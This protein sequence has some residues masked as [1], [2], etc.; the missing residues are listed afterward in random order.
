MYYL[1]QVHHPKTPDTNPEIWEEI[2]RFCGIV[3]ERSRELNFDALIKDPDL[4]HKAVDRRWV[5]TYFGGGF[6]V[7]YVSAIDFGV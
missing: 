6:K 3:S 7:D 2:K 5:L 4:F 1:Q